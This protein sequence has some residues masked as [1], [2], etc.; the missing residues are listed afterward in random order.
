MNVERAFVVAISACLVI[1]QLRRNQMGSIEISGLVGGKPLRV[2][3]L[4]HY[5]QQLS[6]QSVALIPHIYGAVHLGRVPFSAALT[7]GTALFQ[8]V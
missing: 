8:W 2:V 5:P 6:C 1:S 4:S 3:G 7:S